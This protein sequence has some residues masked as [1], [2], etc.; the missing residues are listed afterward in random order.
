VP[1]AL[2]AGKYDDLATVEDARWA[3]E[4]IQSKYLNYKE[5]DQF[6]HSSFLLGKDMSYL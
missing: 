2:F 1:I 4:Q 5:I 6:D 3:K